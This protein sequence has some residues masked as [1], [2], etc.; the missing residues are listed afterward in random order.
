MT[1]IGTRT[2]IRRADIAADFEGILA[3]YAANEWSHA[4]DPERLRTAIDRADLALVGVD[5]DEIIG[6]VRTMSDGAFAVYIADILVTPDRQREGLGRRLL[7]AVL[8]HYPVGEFHHQVLI[9]ERGADGFYR[10]MGLSPVGSFG[11]TAFIRTG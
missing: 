4:R 7:A 3:V 6:F 8:D 9:A 10:R 2:D 5:G 11:L 1:T